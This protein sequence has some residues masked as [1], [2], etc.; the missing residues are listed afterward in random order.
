MNKKEYF[1]LNNK[2]N[3]ILP[4][5][6]LGKRE[7]DTLKILCS[8]TE[9]DIPEEDVL[10]ADL[11][12][13]DKHLSEAVQEEGWAYSGLDIDT[14]NFELDALPLEDNSVDFAVSLAVI[15]HLSNPTIF[16]NEIN[17]VLKPGGLI[18][19][20]TPNFRLDF[21]NF[22]NDPTHV[23]PYTPSSLEMLLSMHGY[24]NVQTFPGLRCKPRWF[25]SGKYRFMKAQ[26]CF[27]LRGNSKV[28][29]PFLKGYAT[30]IFAIGTK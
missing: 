4:R 25:Y 16:L 21:K 1:Q 17:R 22:Y 5:N 29:L 11:G 7:I 30:S 8:L 26:Y 28:P 6:N 2:K 10:L 24:N 13:G 15:E 12:C 3:L 27:P 20:S 18:Y 9:H 14:L 19:L 23:K